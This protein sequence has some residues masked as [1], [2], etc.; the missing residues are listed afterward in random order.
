MITATANDVS[1]EV[2]ITKRFKHFSAWST[3][4]TAIARLIH[5]ARSFAQST[6]DDTCQGWH[7]CRGGPA[8]EELEKAKIVVIKSVQHECFDKELNCITRGQNLPSQSSLKKLRPI[9]DGSGLLRVGG[10]ITQLGLGTDETNPIFIPGKHHLVT[11]L[12]RQ[13]H[14]AVKHQGRH[15]TE[16]AIRAAGFWI[17][18]AKR[19]IASLLFKCV[20]CKKLHGKTEHQ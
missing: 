5:I 11:L 18:G 9:V 6:P 17:I 7:I 13:Y 19:C 4:I 20:T 8:E 10:R 14:H 2:V 15:L 1:N 16:G 3:L 12:V